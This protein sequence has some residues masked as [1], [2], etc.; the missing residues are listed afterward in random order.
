MG[1]T[2]YPEHMSVYS[3]RCSD[4]VANGRALYDFGKFGICA[5]F[6][7]LHRATPAKLPDRYAEI[8][9]ADA[10]AHVASINFLIYLVLCGRQFAISTLMVSGILVAERPFRASRPWRSSIVA[11]VAPCLLQRRIP[12]DR[13]TDCYVGMSEMFSSNGFARWRCRQRRHLVA[14]ASFYLE[15]CFVLRITSRGGLR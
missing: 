7:F 10:P 15:G 3:S 14:H 1:F 2:G 6:G 4:I 8:G 9:F 12:V 11:A 13:R 5:E